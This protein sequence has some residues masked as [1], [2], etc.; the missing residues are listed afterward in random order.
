LVPDL[1]II[2]IAFSIRTGSMRASIGVF[3]VTLVRLMGGTFLAAVTD[4]VDTGSPPVITMTAAAALVAG[5][6]RFGKIAVYV[7]GV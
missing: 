2:K 1:T 4:S 5:R 7:L 6:A 3:S